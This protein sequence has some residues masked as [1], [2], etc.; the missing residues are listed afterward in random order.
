MNDLTYWDLCEKYSLVQ[1]A[2]LIVGADPVQWTTKI[3]RLAPEDLPL[4][5]GA[6]LQALVNDAE[7]SRLKVEIRGRATLNVRNSDDGRQVLDRRLCL[8]AQQTTVEKVALV[9]WLRSKGVSTPAFFGKNCPEI[10][11][12]LDRTHNNYSRKLAVAVEAWLAVTNDDRLRRGR[13]VKSALRDWIRK[14]L[15]RFGMVPTEQA[16]EEISKVANWQIK[17]GAPKTEPR[18]SDWEKASDKPP[19]P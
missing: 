1:A 13:S 3:S 5:F 11:S 18:I 7:A 16:I 14:N 15:P 2:L 8:N 6:V 19:T 17:G 9:Q 10:P 4:G 12:Y